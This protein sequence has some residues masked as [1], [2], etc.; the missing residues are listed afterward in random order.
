MVRHQCVTLIA[1][2]VLLRVNLAQSSR[3]LTAIVANSL[4]TAP[5]I[6]LENHADA[7]KRLTAEHAEA[8]IELRNRLNV[9]D[10]RQRVLLFRVLVLEKDT[11][12]FLRDGAHP[13]GWTHVTVLALFF[14]RVRIGDLLESHLFFAEVCNDGA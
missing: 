1:H 14:R 7:A 3:P 6:V 2:S 4:S 5:A 9:K 8:R 12:H 11:V 10:L 13:A